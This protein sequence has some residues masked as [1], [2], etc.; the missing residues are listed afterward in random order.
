M[1]RPCFYIPSHEGALRSVKA[2]RNPP[3]GVDGQVADDQEPHVIMSTGYDGGHH[4]V[5]LRD[6]HTG[7]TIARLRSEF[8]KLPI[9]CP[10]TTLMF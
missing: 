1:T 3:S 6:V 8:H 10:L 5:D 9:A 2:I 4:L 7:N